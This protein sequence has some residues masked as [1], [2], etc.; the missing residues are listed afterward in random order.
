MTQPLEINPVETTILDPLGQ[1]SSDTQVPPNAG[2]IL[3]EYYS[4]ALSRGAGEVEAE[5]SAGME[6]MLR[7]QANGLAMQQAE[8]TMDDRISQ[9]LVNQEDPQAVLSDLRSMRFGEWVSPEVSVLLEE[10]ELGRR[11]RSQLDRIWRAN[12]L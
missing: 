4:Q 10:S 11:E 3:A 12:L 1:G 7:Q 9:A 8:S 5:I 6:S 2:R